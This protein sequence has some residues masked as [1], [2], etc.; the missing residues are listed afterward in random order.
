MRILIQ[1]DP[2]SRSVGFLFTTTPL[3]NGG[4]PRILLDFWSVRLVLAWGKAAR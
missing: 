2:S 3:L 1:R 4:K